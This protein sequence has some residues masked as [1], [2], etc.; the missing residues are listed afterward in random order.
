MVRQYAI[1]YIL[2]LALWG[3]TACG[4]G[5]KEKQ[6]GQQ[7]ASSNKQKSDKLSPVAQKALALRD[8]VKVAWDSVNTM[9]EQKFS[10]IDRLLEEISY[11]PEH[12]S[13]QYRQLKQLA[14]SVNKIRYSQKSMATSSEINQF[15]K[16]TNRLLK[17]LRTYIDSTPK[18]GQYQ[19]VEQLWSDIKTADNRIIFV[20]LYYDKHVRKYNQF[21]KKNREAL[22]SM[23]KKFSSMEPLPKFA[24]EPAS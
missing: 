21:I 20:R 19:L 8:S 22:D 9:H 24:I 15:D 23:G 4:D 13:Q 5:Q 6:K 14:D 3:L 10:D 2:L 18:T 17:K 11:I 7:E 12:N 16:A 1:L